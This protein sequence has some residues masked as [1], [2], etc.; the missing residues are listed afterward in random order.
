MYHRWKSS[1]W[2]TKI[3]VDSKSLRKHVNG[4]LFHPRFVVHFT[5]RQSIIYTGRFN[6]ELNN[7]EKKAHKIRNGANQ[8]S[9]INLNF[10]IGNDIRLLSHICFVYMHF[11]MTV[12]TKN[13][14]GNDFKCFR[15][16]DD[17]EHMSLS[18]PT[19]I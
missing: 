14:A 7:D 16:C 3:I 17:V 19:K 13:I 12:A 11:D 8:D 6:V 1:V 18:L 10:V 9:W 4:D 15:Q 5:C 2:N